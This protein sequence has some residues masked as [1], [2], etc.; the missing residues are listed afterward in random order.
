MASVTGDDQAHF[1]KVFGGEVKTRVRGDN[2]MLPLTQAGSC[3]G[4]PRF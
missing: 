3:S 1:L 2:I 4:T